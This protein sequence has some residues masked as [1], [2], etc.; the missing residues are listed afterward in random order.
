MVTGRTELLERWWR[1]EQKYVNKTNY[2]YSLFYYYT[3]NTTEC[4]P[5]TNNR[6]ICRKTRYVPMT[7]H[8]KYHVVGTITEPCRWDSDEYP[9]DPRYGKFLWVKTQIEC[10][11]RVCHSSLAT[12]TE[13]RNRENCKERD[14][15][16]IMNVIMRRVRVTIFIVQ[17]QLSI[18]YTFWLSVFVL[19]YPAWTAHAPCYTA[20]CGLPRCTIFSHIFP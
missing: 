7:L 13:T 17:Q 16:C 15:Q 6:S 18:Y 3:S 5:S 8:H 12:T 9:P 2:I 11:S 1:G 4:P 14:R 20:I 19:S 10:C